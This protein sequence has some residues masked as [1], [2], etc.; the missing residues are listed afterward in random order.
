MKERLIFFIS[1]AN[2]RNLKCFNLLDIFTYLNLR[3]E[4]YEYSN[5]NIFKCEESV[6]AGVNST[7]TQGEC[8]GD[9]IDPPT[10]SV[11]HS[12]TIDAE[13]VFVSSNTVT[14]LRLL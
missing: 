8:G 2:N 12:P 11:S 14:I 1:F 4:F 10:V 7:H 13:Y 6:K 5:V 3:I 9:S